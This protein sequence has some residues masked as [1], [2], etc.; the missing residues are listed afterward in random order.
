M[1][2]LQEAGILIPQGGV[3]STPEQAYEIASTMGTLIN[4]ASY[5]VNSLAG[6][7]RH[8]FGHKLRASGIMPA[9]VYSNSPRLCGGFPD[10]ERISQSP[11]QVTKSPR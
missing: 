9:C 6:L 2:L 3:A 7:C 5:H 1:K 11:V 10:L 4:I 8:N